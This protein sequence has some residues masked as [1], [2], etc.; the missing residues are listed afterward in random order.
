MH[1]RTSS[2]ASVLPQPATSAARLTPAKPAQWT[3]RI[4]PH[5]R[6]LL[7]IIGACCFLLYVF[8]NEV[9]T[10]RR[11]LGYL[12]RPLWDRP[13]RAFE[14]VPHYG[15]DEALSAETFCGLHGWNKRQG[16]PP[17]IVDAVLVST[18]IDM[19]EI[20]W[21]EYEPYVDL[22]VVV[23]SNMTFAGTPKHKYFAEE[24]MDTLRNRFDFIPRDKIVYLAIDNLR[25]NLP[26]GSFENEATMRE[27][28][29]QLL[30]AQA[31]EGSIPPGSLILHSDVDEIISRDTLALLTICQAFPSPLH[32]N[33]KNY[34]YGFSFPLAD[35]GYWRPKVI[36][37]DP[38]AT[39]DTLTY[40]HGRAAD[41]ILADAGWHC[42]W[43][44]RTLEEMRIKMLGYSHNDRVRNRK[45]LLDPV[46]LR[47]RVCRGDEPF[48][49]LPESY[50]FRDLIKQTGPLTPSRTFRDVPVALKQDPKRFAYLLD[51]GC[52]RAERE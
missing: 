11:D 4:R 7:Y 31:A 17:I 27:R 47:Q 36:T 13:E 26:L 48:G 30:H 23:E 41:V 1:L 46:K 2:N 21:K 20:R 8:A 18:E 38:A 5:R 33:V 42:S 35:A 49:M 50:T 3:H 44:F 39:W 28:V 32:L 10:A 45:A 51:D 24:W 15:T 34:R 29:T 6:T 16:A 12:L 52:A 14:V 37:H 43:C 22:F 25:P 40:G 19:L 9:G